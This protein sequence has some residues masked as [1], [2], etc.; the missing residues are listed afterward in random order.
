MGSGTN[1]TL[2]VA[3][4][5][6]AGKL[7]CIGGDIALVIAQNAESMGASEGKTSVN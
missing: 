3:L 7:P 2:T 5:W 6:K 1:A 4:S